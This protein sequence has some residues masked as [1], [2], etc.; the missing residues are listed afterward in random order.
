MW[1]GTDKGEGERGGGG[2]EEERGE[3]V[4]RKTDEAMIEAPLLLTYLS[5]QPV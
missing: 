1:R 3:C 5:P 4:V 2:G